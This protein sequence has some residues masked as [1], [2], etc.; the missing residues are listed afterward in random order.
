[1]KPE[2][3][4]A[5][6]IIVVI[7]DDEAARHSIGQMLGLRGWSVEVFSSAEAALAWPGLREALCIITDV[8]MPGMDGEEFLATVRSRPGLTSGGDAHRPRRHRH[9]GALPEVRG[10]RVRREAV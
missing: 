4:Q 9:G 8:K 5:G 1:M 6:G 3:D 10:I 2:G 7:D